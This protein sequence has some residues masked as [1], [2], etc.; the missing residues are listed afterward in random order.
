MEA[1]DRRSGLECRST[2][3]ENC[4]QAAQIVLRGRTR[5]EPAR[6]LQA[7]GRWFEPSTAH[8]KKGL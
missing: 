2:P 7:G 6:A 4:L 3:Q 8:R 1:T 5:K